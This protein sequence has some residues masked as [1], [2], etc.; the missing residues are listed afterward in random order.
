MVYLYY[1]EDLVACEEALALLLREAVPAEL[2]DLAVTRLEGQDLS[3]GTLLEHCQALPFLSPKRVVIVEGLADWLTKKGQAEESG[4]LDK[5]RDYLPRMAESTLL[6]FRERGA[7]AAKHPLITLVEQVGEAHEFPAPRPRELSQWINRHVQR[8]DA[9]ITVAAADLLAAT[10]G[11]DPAVLRHEIDK[12]VTY[13]G[14]QGRIDERL[15]A[16]LA[17]EARLSDIFALVDAIGQQRQARAMVELQ[18]LLQAGH[19][20]LYILAMIVRQFRLLLQVRGLPAGSR[21]PEQ[22]ARA[23]GIHP[24]VAEKVVAQSHSFRRGDLEG[25]YHRLVE[26]DRDIKTGQRDAEV[27][28]ELAVVDVTGGEV[29]WA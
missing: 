22:V 3:L 8:Q 23:M 7:L 15:V 24:F 28:L 21:Q 1:G 17:S 26:T 6:I 5:L 25:I 4:L 12:L 10:V 14:P 11:R 27:A 13:V 29:S 20:P 16:E 19:H 9:E 18:R 2:H